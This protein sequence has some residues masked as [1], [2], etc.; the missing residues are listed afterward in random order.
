LLFAASV[1]ATL[2]QSLSMAAM[3]ELPMP[4]GWSMSMLWM[5][6][7]GRTWTRGAASFAGMWTVMMAAMMLPSLAQ[8]LA[9]Y[10]E[11][12]GSQVR[13][14]ELALLTL[15]VAGG[16]WAVWIACGVAV[17]ALGAALATAE[18]RWQTLARA[19]PFAAGLAVLLAGVLQ[20]GAWKARH[21]ACCRATPRIGADAAAAWRHGVRIGI[22]CGCCCAGLT[23]V[24]LVVGMMDL[25][26]MAVV[27][28]AIIAERFSPDGARIARM[29][30]AMAIGGGLLLIAHA[31]VNA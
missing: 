16:Y 25:R 10:R 27:T 29:V 22:H 5:P 18:L 9:R 3:G 11:A 13:A 21:L 31:A 7:C 6:A 24:Q 4:G 28:A 19:V 2:A 14:T 15:R 26:M 17:F 23:A 1:A 12:V 30:G 8:M 20:L